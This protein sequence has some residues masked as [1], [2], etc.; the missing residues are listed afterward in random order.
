[1]SLVDM[2]PV[3]V[4]RKTADGDTGS[5]S[6]SIWMPL[7]AVLLLWL[8]VMVWGIVGLVVAVRVLL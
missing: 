7:F 5:L 3:Y 2:M 4:T 8:N 1:M 6:L